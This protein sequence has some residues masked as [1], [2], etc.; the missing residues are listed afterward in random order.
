MARITI[1]LE[2]LANLY[3]DGSD[4]IK[5]VVKNGQA[6]E[7]AGADSVIFGMGKEYDQRRKR[8]AMLLI[9]SL[10][11]ALAIRCGSDTRSF[12]ATQ[13]LKPAMAMLKFTSERRETPSTAITNLQ[14]VNILVGME[15]GL[16]IDQIKEAARLKCDYAILNCE[17]F[18]AARTVNAQ[19]DELGKISKLAGLANRLSMGVIASGDFTPL[20]LSKL[21]GAAQIEEYIMGLPFISN[22]LIH[23]YSKALDIL[24]HALS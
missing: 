11:I 20:H 15:V 21:S 17:S 23:G 9:D 22:A 14:V 10:D 2:P 3:S 1:D 19:L 18:C 7:I 16:D 12:E 8:A 13:D 4:M 24:R 6:C 5:A